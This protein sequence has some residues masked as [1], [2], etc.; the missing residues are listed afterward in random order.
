MKNLILIFL[1]LGVTGAVGAQDS[2]AYFTA[3]GN[4]VGS[5]WESSGKWTDGTPFSQEVVVSGSLR[6]KLIKVQTYSNEGGAGT[7]RTLRNDGIRAW[8]ATASKMRFWEFDIH[9]GITEGYCTVDGSDIY[10]HYH[11]DPGGGIM[12]LTDGWIQ[13]DRDTYDYKVGVF[14]N[15]KWTKV[16]LEAVMRR[17]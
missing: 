4:L 7:E 1:V 13:K 16:F 8:D 15:G 12:K 17:Q 5:K 6:G 2:A 10:Y 9:G 3:F 11:Y 14:E